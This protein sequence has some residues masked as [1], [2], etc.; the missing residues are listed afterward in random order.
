ML[1]LFD[2]TIK[3]RKDEYGDIIVMEGIFGTDMQ[4]LFGKFLSKQKY[5]ALFLSLYK[6]EISFYA[7][8]ALEVHELL[9][10]IMKWKPMGG[11]TDITL[12][13]NRKVIDSLNLKLQ[14]TKYLRDKQFSGHDSSISKELMGRAKSQLVLSNIKR[15]MNYGILPHQEKI[16][17]EYAF[18]KLVDELRGKLFAAEPGTGKTFMSLALALAL[19]VDRV[20]IVAPKATI[21]EVWISSL[22]GEIYKKPNAYFTSIDNKPYRGEKYIVVHYEYIKHLSK[23]LANDGGKTMFIVDESHNLNEKNPQRTKDFIQLV[24][25]VEPTDVV[26][27][28]GTSI[29]GRT[30]EVSNMFRFCD[31][32]FN[33][34]MESIFEELYKTPTK[35]LLGILP[36]RYGYVSTFVSKDGVKLP[37]TY[38]IE[39]N[40]TLSNGKYFELESIRDRMKSYALERNTYYDDNAVKF[41][42]E[43]INLRDKALRLSL[44]DGTLDK[45]GLKQYIADIKD[46]KHRYVNGG[47]MD[48]PITLKRAN[49]FETNDIM[50]YLKGKDLKDFRELKSVIKYVSLKIQGEILARVVMR[51]RI[52]LA[53]S[54]AEQIDYKKYLTMTEKKTLMFSSYGEACDMAYKKAS[55]FTKCLQVYWEHTKHLAETVREFHTNDKAQA[56]VATYKSLST[57]VEVK[58]ANL[59]IFFDLPFKTYIYGQA[60]ARTHRIGQDKPCTFL[61]LIL[62]T[63]NEPNINSRNIDIIQESKEMVEL[64]TRKEVKLEFKGNDKKGSVDD[65][66]K[67]F[68]SITQIVDDVGIVGNERDE[69]IGYHLGLFKES[70]K[71]SIP[72]F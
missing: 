30:L 29:K 8:F 58:A 59:T 71:R 16:F 9:F 49:D 37:K 28:T 24:D 64:I 68:N 3:I 41:E 35:L 56:C 60:I 70:T 42:K 40:I 33:A 22:T 31:P 61:Q 1:H 39:E 72:T 47:L 65:K 57:G 46:I 53:V 6:N 17:E 27:L 50:P 48:V 62:D 69:F 19:E 36:L 25:E 18:V 11:E 45:D 7:Y 15:D 55:K 20:V 13:L 34:K 23:F 5:N 51:T 67:K 4:E 12:G 38:T 26:L 66:I 43:Y 54:M 63:G 10:A 44:K 14:K 21:E 2:G 32:N 52:D